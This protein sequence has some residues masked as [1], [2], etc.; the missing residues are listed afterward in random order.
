MRDYITRLEDSGQLQHI[1]V[2]VEPEFELAAVTERSQQK[3]DDALL[4]NN[5]NG[6]EFP[7]VT[8]VYG[9]RERLCALIGAEDGK[10]YRQW[11]ARLEAFSGSGLAATQLQD[12]AR[13]E[14]SGKL[15]DLPLITY[16]EQD[17]GP[18]F[19]S[20]IFLAKDPAT[21]TANLSFHRCMY[22][23]DGELRVR[24]GES[25]DLARYHAAAE[26]RGEAL[27]AAI[28]IGPPPECF[29]SACASLPYTAD[30][31]TAAA[32]IA[33][34]IVPV[35]AG[36][37]VD[38]EIPVGTQ[39][40]IEGRLLPDVRR[41]EGPFGEFMGY[42]VP[43]ADNPV[44]EVSAVYWQH[45]AVFHSLN[46]G[47]PEDSHPLDYAI[48]ARIYTTLTANIPGIIDVACYPRIMN[49]IVQIRQQYE[50]HA[51]HVLLAT[52]G[53]HTD[54]SKSCMV[55][56]EDVDIHNLDEVFW[57]YLTR[58]R[59]DTR[60]FILNDV[61]GFYRDPHK[62]HWGRLAIDATKP[63]HRQK[64]FERKKIPGGEDID[65]DRYLRD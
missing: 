32:A 52:I 7:V 61:P 62:D 45:D 31:M 29:L 22:V 25:H 36:R 50:G 60:A 65:L 46:C 34:R 9:S 17:A 39:I 54:Y 49:T 28:L 10:Y 59:A 56:D 35:Q 26:S 2:D 4:F 48:A 12:A 55:I 5:V 19:T 15:S 24:L 3:S 27:E 23:D 11:V 53:A 44:F 16:F 58:G 40:V 1:D 20:T 18:Y 47:S 57:A 30:E 13:G 41:P 6:T 51:K 38:L 63:Y 8:N 14:T 37:T 64:E 43:V 33:G 21:G 42:Y